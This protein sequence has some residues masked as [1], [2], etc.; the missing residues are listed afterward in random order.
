MRS[1]HQIAITPTG[2]ER[3]NHSQPLPAPCLLL[4]AGTALG[5]HS[6]LGIIALR[7]SADPGHGPA[8][9][10]LI[11]LLVTIV[12]KTGFSR[13]VLLRSKAIESQALQ[14]EGWHHHSDALTSVAA[15]VG[16]SA[17]LIGGPAWAQADAWA[18]L[19]SCAV[20]I[21]NGVH[22]A[23]IMGEVLDAEAAPK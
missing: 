15:A 2:M 4:A 13:W 9:F 5:W 14:T 11:I 3:W 10:T 20:I 19:F 18:A 23:G 17:A 22:A 8:G 16:I 12:I 1:V 21:F 7:G 6:V